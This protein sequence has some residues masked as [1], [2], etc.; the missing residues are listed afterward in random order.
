[1]CTALLQAAEASRM[2]LAYERTEAHAREM[3]ALLDGADVLV[4]KVHRPRLKGKAMHHLVNLKLYQG[5]PADAVLLGREAVASLEQAMQNP[6]GAGYVEDC[7]GMLMDCASQFL[8]T[9]QLLV[10]ALD[11]PGQKAAAVEVS[12]TR[13]LP[14]CVR[15]LLHPRQAVTQA[16]VDAFDV[17]AALRVPLATAH[18]CFYLERWAESG[19]WVGRYTDREMLPIRLRC[20]E[21][22]EELHGPNHPNVVNDKRAL[23]TK[24]RDLLELDHMMRLWRQQKGQPRFPSDLRNGSDPSSAIA[25]VA[26]RLFKAWQTGRVGLMTSAIEL[27][28][29]AVTE[30]RAIAEP[31]PGLAMRLGMHGCMLAAFWAEAGLAKAEAVARAEARF[32]EAI[33][34]L[35][36]L[37]GERLL[38]SDMRNEGGGYLAWLRSYVA[39]LEGKPAAEQEGEAA[40]ARLRWLRLLVDELEG[41]EHEITEEVLSELRTTMRQARGAGE[42]EDDASLSRRARRRLEA[43]RRANEARRTRRERAARSRQREEEHKQEEQ[44]DEEGGGEEDEEAEGQAA[45]LGQDDVWPPRQE[46]KGEGEEAEE[47]EEEAD[48]CAICLIGLGEEG[49]EVLACAHAYHARCLDAWRDR[50]R[51]KEVTLTCPYCRQKM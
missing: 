51:A 42:W 18:E 33:Q 17:A 28:D 35:Q 9:S 30:A 41:K 19:K 26:F 15:M 49:L 29:E 11:I 38:G 45:L 22:T 50:C 13:L 10:H 40:R 39:L 7:A 1:M 3:L 8:S 21:R 24:Y 32:E 14:V 46:G 5:R 25:A 31:Y 36:A 48:E 2:Q 20:L 23:L 27:M 6:P 34:A 12:K 44:E 43:R 47:E 4:P 16:E 37:Y